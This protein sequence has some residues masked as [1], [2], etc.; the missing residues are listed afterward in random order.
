MKNKSIVI[1]C[2]DP[3]STF[4][5][6]LTKTLKKRVLKNSKFPLI[7]IGSKK[8]LENEFKKLKTKV[9]L[10]K[11]DSQANLR[12]NNLYIIDIPLKPKNHHLLK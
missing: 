12:N 11:F 4:N 6:I 5:E 3:K 10:H 2:G 8:L 9:Q 1:I 7:L